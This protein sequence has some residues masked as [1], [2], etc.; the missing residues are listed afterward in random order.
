MCSFFASRCCENPDS[1]D[2]GC[3]WGQRILDDVATLELGVVIV[4]H[5][6]EELGDG[7]ED[8]AGGCETHRC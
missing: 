1:W 5:G 3:A 6:G 7:A 4:T 8:S 2:E